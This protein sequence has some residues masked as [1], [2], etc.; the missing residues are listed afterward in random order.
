MKLD[1]KDP[2]A[3]EENKETPVNSVNLVSLEI[4]DLRVVQDP[5]ARRVT[6]GRGVT[7]VPREGPD[8]LDHPVLRVILAS[9]SQLLPNSPISWSPLSARRRLELTTQGTS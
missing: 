6:L 4:Q 1:L 7:P 8:S 3:R 5:P 2:R 9:V